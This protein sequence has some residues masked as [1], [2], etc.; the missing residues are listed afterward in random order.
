MIVVQ[1]IGG[2]C[3]NHP[4]LPFFERELF[5]MTSAIKKEIETITRPIRSLAT[6]GREVDNLAV[7][8][9]DGYGFKRAVE[10]RRSGGRSRRFDLDMREA[11]FLNCI[12]V[13]R[14]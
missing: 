10:N 2:A 5:Q 3:I 8:G 11:S 14:A 12:F 13:M 7:A 1:V 4:W 9:C 6:T